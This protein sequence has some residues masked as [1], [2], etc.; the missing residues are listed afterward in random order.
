MSE[1]IGVG[2]WVEIIDSREIAVVGSTC[3]AGACIQC[4]FDGLGIRLIGQSPSQGPDWSWCEGCELR[5]IYRPSASL[6]ESL[7]VPVREKVSP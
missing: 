3:D 6:I 4:D 5:P 7:K 1:P 2:D